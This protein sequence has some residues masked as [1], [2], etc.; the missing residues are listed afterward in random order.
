M[1]LKR[2][3][4]AEL[5]AIRERRGETGAAF[6]AYLAGLAGRARAY[7]RQ[8]VRAWE[9]GDRT[10]PAEIELALIKAGDVAPKR[11][12]IGALVARGRAIKG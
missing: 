9:S 10:V 1:T 5:K 6:G 7:T 11:R 4:G 12:S 2:M 8:E 3:T